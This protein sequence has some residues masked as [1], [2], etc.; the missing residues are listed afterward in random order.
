MTLKYHGSSET[1]R[2]KDYHKP[3]RLFTK[4]M[5]PVMAKLR[6]KQHVNAYQGPLGPWQIQCG[7]D[8]RELGEF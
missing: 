7:L 6:D 5:E 1:L 2:E 8:P 3:L 4:H